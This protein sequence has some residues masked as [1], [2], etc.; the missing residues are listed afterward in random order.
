MGREIKFRAWDEQTKTMVYFTLPELYWMGEGTGD[1]DYPGDR[2]TTQYTGLKDKQGK[3][4]YEGDIAKN[5]KYIC[6]CEWR[7]KF[8]DYVFHA[9]KNTHYSLNYSVGGNVWEVIGNIYENPEL[10]KEV[11]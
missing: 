11:K 7:D 10:L 4:I 5:G 6:V 2:P 9:T 3:E 8:T 1:Y